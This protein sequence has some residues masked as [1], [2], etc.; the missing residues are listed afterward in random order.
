MNQA[1][2]AL[3]LTQLM[4]TAQ[5]SELLNVAPSTLLSWRKQ[6]KFLAYYRVGNRLLY[7]RTD[8]EDFM[9]GARVEQQPVTGV[10]VEASNG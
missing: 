2:S 6:R 9:R 8:V 4:T 10:R 7:H 5:V 1:Q 3:D